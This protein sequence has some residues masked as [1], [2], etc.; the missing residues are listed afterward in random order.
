MSKLKR[1][2]KSINSFE[3]S[4]CSN[5]EDNENNSND[6]SKNIDYDNIPQ[7]KEEIKKIL[8]TK[9]I[10]DL[11]IAKA[12]FK[13]NTHI[14]DKIIN[15]KDQKAII[16]LR[17]LDWFVTRYTKKN[18]ITYKVKIDDKEH[19]FDVYLSYDSQLKSYKKKRFDPFARKNKDS[20]GLFFF[21]FPYTDKKILTNI[22][23]LNFFVWAFKYKIVDYVETNV[24]ELTK[25]MN[26]D[27]KNNRKLREIK[28]KKKENDTL[29]T[30]SNKSN[31]S[32]KEKHKEEVYF[33]IKRKIKNDKESLEITWD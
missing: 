11:N 25:Q 5:Y 4:S 15:I 9:E 29:S 12:F 14:A 28:L 26:I 17:I 7:S 23:Q 22:K 19:D 1:I 13:N 30:A 21:K 18:N 6:S 24:E 32:K 3:K 33:S 16:S 31:K 27:N 2:N 8:K 10:Y 20:T